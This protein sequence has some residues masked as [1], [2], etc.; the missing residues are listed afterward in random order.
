[1]NQ[2][3]KVFQSLRFWIW[4]LVV[5]NVLLIVLPKN[6][7]SSGENR[8]PIV[9]TPS[10]NLPLVTPKASIIKMEQ[11]LEPNELAAHFSRRLKQFLPGRTGS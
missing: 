7:R 9:Q 6:A 2:E 10:K 1:M 8:P 5:L 4:T 11:D 3:S